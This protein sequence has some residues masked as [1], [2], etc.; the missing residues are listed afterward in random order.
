MS[1]KTKT[2]PS[3]RSRDTTS[4][5]YLLGPIDINIRGAKLPSIGQALRVFFYALHIM[6][7]DSRESA[8]LVVREVMLFWDKARIP[9]RKE[10]HCIDQLID[11]Y[12][13]WSAIRK[14]KSRRNGL[15]ERR[16]KEFRDNLDDL[17]DIAHV[18]ALECMKNQADKEFLTRQREKG[19]PG[20]ML[21]IDAILAA[22]EQRKADRLA[23][24]QQRKEKHCTE[25]ARVNGI[26]SI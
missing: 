4:N 12:N 26:I 17:F 15:Q 21:G 8:R 2:G 3:L 6:Q 24:E 14:S 19:R 11:I 9:T 10:C 7:L 20:C 16:E 22:R 18:N 1:S 13:N 23:K 5:I 25:I